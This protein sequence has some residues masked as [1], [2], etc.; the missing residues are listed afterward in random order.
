MQTN[1]LTSQASWTASNLQKIVP[2]LTRPMQL[3]REKGPSQPKPEFGEEILQPKEALWEEEY[4]AGRRGRWDCAIREWWI[5]WDQLCK[6]I[7]I[8]IWNQRRKSNLGIT[9]KPKRW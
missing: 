9:N 2:M 4:K 3:R 6:A 7:S 1:M 5:S 8:S